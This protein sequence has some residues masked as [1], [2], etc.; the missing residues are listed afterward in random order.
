MINTGE[1]HPDEDIGIIKF[2]LPMPI[3]SPVCFAEKAPYPSAEYHM[4]AYPDVI[5]KE[6]ENHE[7]EVGALNFNPSPV[8]FR[9]Y[10]RRSI[11]YS[12]NP[13]LSIYVGNS[14]FE[15]SEIGGSC[16]SG[17]PLST[18]SETPEVFGI[19]IGEETTSRRC[20]YAAN[21]TSILNWIPQSLGRPLGDEVFS[22]I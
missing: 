11:Q 9:G 7:R 1:V 22:S 13:N 3:I 15:V 10:I 19:Y 6:Y 21:L 14:F 20:G 16:C 8:Y 18:I 4:W 12:P 5:A 2:E 17:A